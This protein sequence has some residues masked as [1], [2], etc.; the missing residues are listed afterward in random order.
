MR[1]NEIDILGLYNSLSQCT[2]DQLLLREPT[3]GGEAGGPAILSHRCAFE[4]TKGLLPLN[5]VARK[6]KPKGAATLA[7]R[8][9]VR[10]RIEG[11]GLRQ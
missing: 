8:N 5:Q 6:N 1:F 10:S 3:R 9:A 4:S 11:P 2:S 7:S